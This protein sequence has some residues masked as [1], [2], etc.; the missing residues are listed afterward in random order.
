MTAYAQERGTALSL[1]T[2]KIVIAGILGAIA[3]LLA[4]TRLGFIPVPNL[5]GN[6][7][8]LHVPAIIGG[9]LEGSVVGL[10]V[11]GIFGVFSFIQAEVPAFKDPLVSVLPRLLIGIVAWAVFAGLR[12]VNLYLA[13]VVAGVLG[14]LTNTVGVVGMGILRGY[15][16]AEIWALIAPQAIAEVVI[17][18]I[19][20]VIVVK[21]VDLYRSG[22]TTAPD[23]AGG[24]Y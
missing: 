22:C 3:I 9:V 14:T 1:N 11:G 21:G 24:R 2:R 8:I 4:V 23:T 13:A 18:A 12:P 20:T 5:S 15:F 7:T 19:I 10:L 16:P 6:A 17:A